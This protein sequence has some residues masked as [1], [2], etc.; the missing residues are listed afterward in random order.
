MAWVEFKGGGPIVKFHAWHNHAYAM[1][2]IIILA[3]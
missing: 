3:Q 1:L 2:T